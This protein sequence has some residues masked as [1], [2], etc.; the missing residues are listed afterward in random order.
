ML[1]GR[2]WDLNESITSKSSYVGFSNAAD[3]GE[4]GL[5]VLLRLRMS[6]L[7]DWL[8]VTFE[9]YSTS[10]SCEG[11]PSGLRVLRRDKFI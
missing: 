2:S 4:K 7:Y 9:Y 1:A 11:R 6:V 10:N 5:T 8:A 3:N